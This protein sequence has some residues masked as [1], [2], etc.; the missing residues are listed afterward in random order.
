MVEASLALKFKPSLLEF[1]YYFQPVY[2]KDGSYHGLGG[3]QFTFHALFI[4]LGLMFTFKNRAIS[5][6]FSTL[7]SRR[8]VGDD[9]RRRIKVHIN[10]PEAWVHIEK[11]RIAKDAERISFAFVFL[12]LSFDRKVYN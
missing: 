3:L 9:W 4:N 5:K 6:I 10:P 12:W 1:K 2:N 8:A 11:H 7:F